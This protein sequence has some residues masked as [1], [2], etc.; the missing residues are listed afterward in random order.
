MF[1]VCGTTPALIGGLALAAH[2]VVRATQDIDFLADRDDAQAL[3]EAIQA[4]GYRCF[5]RSDDAANYLRGDEGLDLLYA[6]G[7]ASG[8]QSYVRRPIRTVVRGTRYLL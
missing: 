2:N 8:G 6:H 5:H 7:P 1:T 3:H 4:L